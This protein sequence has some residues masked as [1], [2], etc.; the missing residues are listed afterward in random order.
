[1]IERVDLANAQELDEFVRAQPNCHFMQ[2]SSWGQV[3]R[4]WRWY[5]LLCRG[6]D[7]NICGSLAILR[8]DIRFLHTSML[9]APRG[10]IV[11][12][13]DTETFRLLIDAAKALGKECGAYL[14]RIDP[15][16]EESDKE[17]LRMAEKQGFRCDAASDFSLFQ[18]RMSYISDLR[19][20]TVDTLESHYHRS[21]RYNVHLATRRGITIE[22]GGEADM[23]DFCRMMA[24]TAGKNGF[25]ARSE[26]YYREFLL[27]LGEHVRLYLAK[28]DGKTVAAS[29]TA[30]YGNHA[31][32]MYSCSEQNRETL[33]DRPNDLLQF[34]MQS[35]AIEAGCEFFDFRGVEGYP[36]EENPTIG[37]HRYKEGFGGVFHAYVGQLDL[38]LRPLLYK[39]VPLLQKLYRG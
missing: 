19:G 31:W 30:F 16:I 3:K 35:D 28:K 25:T 39:L 9:Y 29:M 22:L 38:P 1:M 37:L 8:H 23:A 14:L 15:E 5:G 17:F 10:P 24:Q 4:D 12:E 21:T 26:A 34:K 20:L 36:V 7:G 32:Y 13:G 27:G 6:E 2:T 33:S 11:A 18:P